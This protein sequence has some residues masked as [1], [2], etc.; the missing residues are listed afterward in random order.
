M[1]VDSFLGEK[2][3]DILKIIARS[4]A[5]PMELAERLSTTVSYISQQL[6]L[7]E[8][9]GLVGKTRTGAAEKGKPRNIYFLEDEFVHLSILSNEIAAKKKLKLNLYNKAIISIWSIDNEIFHEPYQRF[10]NRVLD[11]SKDIEEVSSKDLI[12]KLEKASDDFDV[13]IRYLLIKESKKNDSNILL[14][15]GGERRE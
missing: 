14:F 4:P 5:S 3:W 12:A 2:R 10:F 8:A 1:E 7:L 9:A 15:H 11:F 6:K 13:R